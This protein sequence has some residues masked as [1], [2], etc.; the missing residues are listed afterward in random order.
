MNVGAI[1]LTA[2]MV[3]KERQDFAISQALLRGY[4]FTIPWS[5][6]FASVIFVM[7][8]LSVN[9][10]RI[11]PLT[12]S[13]STF[14]VLMGILFN[15]LKSRS[16]ERSKTTRTENDLVIQWQKLIELIVMIGL[17]IGSI[18]LVNGQLNLSMTTS[19]S[20]VALIF[21]I[22]WSIY[23]KKTRL[24]WKMGGIYVQDKLAKVKNEV[25]I[26]FSASFFGYI[27][28][29]TGLGNVLPTFFNGMVGNSTFGLILVISFTQ[30]MLTVLGIHPMVVAIVFAGSVVQDIVLHQL[31]I[32]FMILSTWGLSLV[33]S[34]FSVASLVLSRIFNRSPYFIGM[35]LNIFFIL[36]AYLVMIIFAVMIEWLVRL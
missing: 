34:P 7:S 32:S 18:F 10:V 22:L 5:P 3:P 31:T 9:W 4:C 25:L 1:S 26:F 13:Y 29:A 21:P 12:F 16:G 2:D 27:F 24:F 28:L 33:L 17:A 15:F 36:F 30:M 19:V 11:A 23:L 8:L 20:V 35:R 6:F 14:I